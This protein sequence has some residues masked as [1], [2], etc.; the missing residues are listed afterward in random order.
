M[1]RRSLVVLGS[2][3]PRRV[4]NTPFLHASERPAEMVNIDFSTLGLK[5]PVPPNLKFQLPHLGWSPKPSTPPANL[6]FEVERTET[7]KA[8]PVYT[9][10]KGGRTKVVTIIRKIRGDVGEFKQEI[11]KV[12][13][14]AKV[15]VRPGKLVVD[16]NFHKRIKLYLTGLG[17]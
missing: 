12:V 3:P 11:E 14:D 2:K 10:F 4:P 6:P 13:G 9:D 16:G 8:L 5:Y 15:T 1:Y 17:F 7:G